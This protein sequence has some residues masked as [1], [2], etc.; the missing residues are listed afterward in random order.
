MYWTSASATRVERGP[1]LAECPMEHRLIK[2]WR[3]LVMDSRHLWRRDRR[4]LY[5]VVF[6]FVVL[7]LGLVSATGNDDVFITYWAAQALAD[8]G[9]LLNYN[10]QHL[11]Q[12]S[13]LAS[14]LLLALGRKLLP[15]VLIQT[16]GWWL[17][18]M[19]SV[20]VVWASARLTNRLAGGGGALT[21]LVVATSGTFLY[22]AASGMETNLM[23]LALLLVPLALARTSEK[24]TVARRIQLAAAIVLLVLVRPEGPLLACGATALAFACHWAVR[25]MGKDDT[26]RQSVRAHAW[27]LGLS[28][29]ATAATFGFRMLQFGE[30]FPHPVYA[31]VAPG[32][33]RYV[34]GFVYV[35]QSLSPS[36][37]L[38]AGGIVVA[39][40]LLVRIAWR[41]LGASHRSDETD[42][43]REVSLATV[44]ALAL[45]VTAF[46]VASGGD[47]MGFGRF[48]VPAVPLWA[49]LLVGVAGVGAAR[50]GAVLTT[51][52]A[53]LVADNLAGDFRFLR[54]DG[55]GHPLP[56]AMT[57]RR[58]L[59]AS[60]EASHFSTFGTASGHVRDSF[61][62]EALLPYARRINA[63]GE[64]PVTLMSGQAGMIPFH[65]ADDLHGN[66]RLIDLW[67]LTTNELDKCVDTA[68]RGR[69]STG[70]SLDYAWFFG[71]EDLIQ[72]TCGIGRPAIVFGNGADRELFK[73]FERWGYTVVYVQDGRDRSFNTHGFLRNDDVM[74]YFAAVRSDL[75]ARIGCRRV[76]RHLAL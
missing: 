35:L 22:W 37:A 48:V 54:G 31:K 55:S 52:V 26:T 70:V 5:A 68:R 18:M 1:L 28:I 63:L 13:S 45:G 51:L 69:S 73:R 39:V 34:D 9:Q 16:Q 56:A 43:S 76:D 14:V 7:V 71:N 27:G 40:S 38:A 60:P 72:R 50:G 19:A 11:E 25:G 67:M 10:A 49:V 17:S 64:G 65:L 61:V 33:L 23:A 62:V 3:Q 30:L 42:I 20:A 12:S 24:P 8:H 53:V 58:V 46:A 15:C 21:A 41:R 57:I 74:D 44:A 59:A 47:W 6:L 36:G 4:F 32:S 75:C 66:V 2:P 29:L